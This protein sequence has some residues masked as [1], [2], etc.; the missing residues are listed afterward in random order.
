MRSLMR[1][2]RLRD[3]PTQGREDETVNASRRRAEH[4][5]ALQFMS[6]T[7]ATVGHREASVRHSGTEN[8]SVAFR[9]MQL[10][11]IDRQ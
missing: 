2:L 1:P 3:D 5:P 4:A 9:C 6:V 8:C 7:D 10:L 11:N